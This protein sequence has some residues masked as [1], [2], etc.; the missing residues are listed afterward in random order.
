MVDNVR[1]DEKLPQFCNLGHSSWH[2]RPSGKKIVKPSLPSPTLPLASIGYSGTHFVSGVKPYLRILDR[3]PRHAAS[4]R[5]GVPPLPLILSHTPISSDTTLSFQFVHRLNTVFPHT[6]ST[7]PR[8]VCIVLTPALID[9]R[10][11]RHIRIEHPIRDP[12]SQ[13]PLGTPSA[14]GLI[15]FKSKVCIKALKT[16][17]AL[18]I[19]LTT[20]RCL[21]RN[22]IA[23]Q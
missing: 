5:C 23:S 13:P 17:Q 14:K 21:R 4:L 8:L 9:T 20:V 16:F 18:H 19:A 6:A 2:C 3:D 10:T 7:L 22:T 1:N 15:E 12:C 11:C